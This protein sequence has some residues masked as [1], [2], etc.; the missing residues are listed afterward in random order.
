MANDL[1]LLWFTTLLSGGITLLRWKGILKA[2]PSVCIV[3][4]LSSISMLVLYYSPLY[5]MNYYMANVIKIEPLIVLLVILARID[6]SPNWSYRA[7]CW[8]LILHIVTD[9]MHILTNLNFVYF[10]QFSLTT[11]ILEILVL[12][13]G[14]LNVRFTPVGKLISRTQSIDNI[15]TCSTWAKRNT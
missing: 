5:G 6:P 7:M 9:G 1:L 8:I 2:W 10:D 15:N 3:S 11:S 4:F 12:I 14:G 13:S